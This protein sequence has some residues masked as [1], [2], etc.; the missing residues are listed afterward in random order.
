MRDYWYVIAFSVVLAIISIQL[1]NKLIIIFFFLWLCTLQFQKKLPTISLMLTI[2][3]FFFFYTYIPAPNEQMMDLPEEL[4]KPMTFHGEINGPIQQTDKKVEFLFYDKQLKEDVLI[5]YFPNEEEVTSTNINHVTTGGI[6]QLNGKLSLP[7][8]ARNPHQFDYQQYLLKQGITYQIILSSLSDIECTTKGAW[9]QLYDIR[10]TLIKSTQAHL[11]DFTIAWLHALVLGDKSKL[12]DDVIEVFQRWGL[13]HILAISG[14]HIGIVV[15]IVYFLLVKSSLL[16]KEKAQ[17]LIISFLPLYAFIAGGQPSVWR[18]SLMVMFVMLLNKL[19][20][21]LNYTDIVS[22]VFLLL[23]I[24]DPYIVYHI[25]FQFSFAVT[26]GLIVSQQWMMEATSN[27]ERVLQISFVS[28]MIILPLQ[29]QYFSLFQPLSIMM[30]VFVVPYFSFFIIPAMF[31]LLVIHFLPIPFIP[32]FEHFFIFVHKYFLSGLYWVDQHLDYSFVI[33]KISLY[34]IIVYYILFLMM[35]KYIERKQLKR[36]FTYG[37]LLCLCMITISI[38]PYLSPIGSVTMLDVGQGDAFIIELPYRRGVFFIDMGAT[39]RFDNETPNEAM[40]NNRIKP[41]LM[42][43]GITKIDAV[44]IS[45]E[46]VD[47]YGSLLY[48]M[49]DIAIDEM[50]ISPYYEV[51][52]DLESVWKKHGISV[53]RMDFNESIMRNGQTFHSLSPQRNVQDANENSLVLYSEFGGKSWFFTGDIGKNTEIE[54]MNAFPHLRFDVLKVGHH[55]SNTSTESDF[56]AMTEPEVALISV[57]EKNMYG[58]PAKAV[59]ETLLNE[60]ILV[61]RTD[62]HGAVQYIYKDDVGIFKPFLK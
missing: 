35:M 11:D 7:D 15:A 61:Y 17:W 25:G 39:F 3:S 48:A 9:H 18:A 20:W 55:G 45:H 59:I 50:I 56:I 44:F 21:R 58:H 38:R 28:Q 24:V 6:C 40:Y 22:I 43:Q 37:L 2:C 34:F 23:I 10:N 30:N 14:L 16:T 26:F 1:G 49:E 47:H 12:D 36:A 46:H 53:Y 41:Y 19:N 52:S 51:T 13:S 27:L 60:G 4:D 31:G 32:S 29:I 42:G 33:G 8:S 62:E 5:V 54:I 57:G